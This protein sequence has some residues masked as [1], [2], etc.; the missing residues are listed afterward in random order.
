MVH[1]SRLRDRLGPGLLLGG[2]RVG[3]MHGL[4]GIPGFCV[5]W[6]A[7]SSC[8]HTAPS[9]CLC[10]V[11]L[12]LWQ[13]GTWMQTMGSDN[14]GEPQ[15]GGRVRGR[16]EGSEVW[17]GG[18][19]WNGGV[20]GGVV[21][22]WGVI[23][24]LWEA[25]EIFGAHQMRMAVGW[26]AAGWLAGWL[27]GQYDSCH[28]IPTIRFVPQNTNNNIRATADHKNVISEQINCMNQQINSIENRKMQL[29]N[30]QMPLIQDECQ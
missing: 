27:A 1:G 6:K 5:S 4:L 15:G 12:W 28:R 19:R 13:L 16:G 3:G 2:G 11:Q 29:I 18:L 20:A 21:W 22:G 8:F 9:F 24:A 26:M 30:R 7:W 14:L 10:F 25:F 17:C 23:D